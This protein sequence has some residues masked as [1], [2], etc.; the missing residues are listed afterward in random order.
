MTYDERKKKWW[1][2]HK[3]NPSVWNYFQRFSM[4]AVANGRTKISHHIVIDRIR[5]ETAIVSTNEDVKI[6]HDY[7]AFY[8]RLWKVKYPQYADLFTT[9]RMKGEH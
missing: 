4:E 9:K 5:W 6:N 1:A 2:W 3:E 7:V 8:A